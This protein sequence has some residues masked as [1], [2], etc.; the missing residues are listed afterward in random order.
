M[1]YS[2]KNTPPKTDIPDDVYVSVG[3]PR[4]Y[5]PAQIEDY[6]GDEDVIKI[7]S[8]YV[9]NIHQEFED[10]V[11]LFLYGENG[12]GKTY[13]SSII[14]REA[15]CHWYKVKRITLKRWIDLKLTP[16][17]NID[18]DVWDELRQ[19]NTAE[20]LCIDEVGKESDTKNDINISLFEELLKF[21]E[22]K[23]LPTILCS[24]LIPQH[25][26][27]KYGATISSLIGQSIKIELVGG[28]MRPEVF[29]KR[30]GVQLLFDEEEV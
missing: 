14:L 2:R 9:G 17:S 13:L 12:K 29:K 6:I 28:D 7:L 15:M 25:I 8:R 5:I 4:P 3:I 16:R 21:R 20:F 11:N 23:G 19:V 24:N 27:A 26:E 30:K 22:E 18:E 10:G 1:L